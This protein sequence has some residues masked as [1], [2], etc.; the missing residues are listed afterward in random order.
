M[1]TESPLFSADSHVVEPENFWPERI[2]RRFRD[3]APRVV[4]NE[5]GIL[6]LL[7]PGLPPAVAAQDHMAGTRGEDFKRSLKGGFAEASTGVRP[8]A[9]PRWRWRRLS[10]RA[11]R[12]GPLS[13]TIR[14]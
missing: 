12:C 11:A 8:G 14:W 13:R 6:A 2:G 10:I 5:H 3:Q 9:H 7:I 4:K 1:T